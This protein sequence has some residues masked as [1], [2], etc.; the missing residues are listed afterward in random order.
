MCRKH[1]NPPRPTRSTVVLGTVRTV[2]VT[3][4]NRE[5]VGVIKTT[6]YN[7]PS[8][9]NADGLPLYSEIIK[10]SE[11]LPPPYTETEL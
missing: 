4:S 10:T 11:R 5:G 6:T 7:Q 8:T 2:D 1:G 3:P 9:Y